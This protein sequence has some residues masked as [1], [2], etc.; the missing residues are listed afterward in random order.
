MPTV[1]SRSSPL[2][3]AMAVLMPFAV[4][5][6]ESTDLEIVRERGDLDAQR[7]HVWTVLAQL[8][9][10]PDGKSDPAFESWYGEGD[11]FSKVLAAVP[12]GRGI[13]AFS[14][15][16]A[17]AREADLPFPSAPVFAYTL[18]N[19]V[20][21]DHIRAHRLN[22]QSE[23]ERL[24]GVGPVDREIIADRSIP[25][26]PHGTV[27]V[28]T[29]WWPVAEH[30]ITPLPVWDP[31]DNPPRRSGNNY[32]EW[33]RAIIIN[34]D[35]KTTQPSASNR[36]EFA[37]RSF[38][39]AP[40]FGLTAFYHVSVDA[41]LARQVNRDSEARRAS[42]I[43]LGRPI[44]AGD[45]LALVGMNLATK[46]IENWV[47]ASF[48]WHDRADQGPFAAGRPDALKSAWRNYLMQVA[49]DAEKPAERQG[50]A[51]ICFNPWLEARFPDAGNGG[52]VVSNCL[53]C[54]QRASFPFVNFLPVTRGAPDFAAD[55][56]YAGG[57]LR[58]GFLWSIALH[59]TP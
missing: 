42:L 33:Q 49:F 2:L 21:Y 3:V 22:R 32:M 7:Q 29:I 34:P 15:A 35:L 12:A 57:R 59:A 40:A 13:R 39:D 58:T 46:D 14:R 18:Y 31:E 48:W 28:K 52:G 25:P 5:P 16:S 47:W 27:I 9:Q 51:H 20:A 17:T 4:S 41:R 55:P 30:G 36:V 10:S 1:R 8:L 19:A 37:G 23:L 54:H 44:K 43:A 53:A 24:R 26:F 11:V 38:P 6:K 45:H 50:G 56:A